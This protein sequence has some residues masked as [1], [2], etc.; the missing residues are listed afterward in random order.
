MSTISTSVIARTVLADHPVG[1]SRKRHP[2]RVMSQPRERWY[3]ASSMGSGTNTGADADADA[4]AAELLGDSRTRLGGLQLAHARRVAAA[5]RVDGEV[6]VAAALLHDVVE[7]G[8]IADRDLDVVVPDPRVV[9]L[10]RCLTR[11]PGESY[12]L[13]LTRCAGDPTAL[14]IKRADLADKL[15]A[16]DVQVSPAAAETIRGRARA[17]L[18]M[19]DQIAD[20]LARDPIP[21]A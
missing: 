16:P 10:V 21:A 12:Q 20:R 2:P 15:D 3:T 19:L 6:A 8:Q 9:A 18:R 17:R 4:L 13:Y 7:T 5:V 11:D 1:G 14:L